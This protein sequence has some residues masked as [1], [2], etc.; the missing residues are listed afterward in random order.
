MSKQVKVSTTHFP[1]RQG[2]LAAI[3]VVKVNDPSSRKLHMIEI[4]FEGSQ[5]TDIFLYKDYAGCVIDGRILTVTDLPRKVKKLWKVVKGYAVS[6]QFPNVESQE[7]EDFQT[8]VTAAMDAAKGV[9]TDAAQTE[10][11]KT[12]GS[13]LKANDYKNLTMI[14][15]MKLSHAA[16]TTKA[17]P[18]MLRMQKLLHLADEAVYRLLHMFLSD[19][20]KGFQWSQVGDHKE[21]CWS[22]PQSSYKILFVGESG[23]PRCDMYVIAAEG[24][25]VKCTYPSTLLAVYDA[26]CHPENP[27]V[28]QALIVELDQL[29]TISYRAEQLK[30]ALYTIPASSTK[31]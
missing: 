7:R 17:D 2:S 13:P 28:H 11:Q 4:G 12:T 29:M 30:A 24:N 9:W 3:N 23:A 22:V 10:S 14:A 16:Q 27:S 21:G 6:G 26:V 1:I 20:T 25:R 5:A 8:L 18:Y 15:I 19:S 31:E